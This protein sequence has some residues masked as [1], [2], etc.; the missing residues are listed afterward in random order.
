MNEP[1]NKTHWTKIIS[2][3]IL[4]IVSLSQHLYAQKNL[5]KFEHLT[6][7]Q[8]LLNYDVL[9]IVQDDKGFMWFATLDGL[10][11]YDGY[12]LKVY[13]QDP[14]VS[15]SLSDNPIRVVYEDRTGVLWIGTFSGGLNR[16]DRDTETFTHYQHNPADPNSLSNDGIRSIYQDRTGTL[17]IGTNGGGLNRFDSETEQ[18]THYQHDPDNPRSLGHDVI[19]VINEDRAG[20][21]WIGTE[22]GGLNRFDRKNETFI[23]Y[24]NNP[25]DPRSL[26]H[27]KVR[28]I[29]E[30]RTGGFWVGTFGGGLNRFDRDTETFTHYQHNPADP[31]S[32][33]D[34]DILS[35]Y[36]DRTGGLWIGTL[37]G[38]LN[39]FDRD[40][41]TFTHYQHNPADPH[42]L[43]HNNVYTIYED[44]TDVLW[45]GTFGG[46][47]RLDRGQKKFAHYQHNSADPNSLSNSDVLSIYEDKTGVL[48][49]GT[50]G[51]GLNHFDQETGTFTYYQH[52]SA[53]PGS[54]SNNSVCA[55]RGDGLDALWIG[56]WGGGLNRFD[57]ETETFTHYRHNP[58]NPHSLSDDVIMSIHKDRSG[59]L[60]IGTWTGG[61]DKLVLNEAKGFDREAA[62]FVHYQHNP[63]DP[64][65]LGSNS[66]M[67][68]YED[69]TGV[70]WV[71]TVNGGLNRFDHETETF[72]R[73]KND[74][75][76]PNSLSHNS[77]RSIYEDRAGVLWIGTWGGGLNRFDRESERFVRYTEKDGLPSNVVGGILEDRQ[78]N[79]WLSTSRGLS[80]FNPQMETFRNYNRTDGLQGNQ[81]NLNNGYYKSRSGEMFFGGTNGFN[82]FYPEQ[83]KDNP[84]IPPIAITNFQLANKPASIGGDSVLQQSIL[85]TG[86]L[87]LSYLDRVFSFEF[88]ALNYQSPEKNLYKYKLEGFDDG[89]NELDSTRRFATYTHLDQGE[90]VFR[91]IGSNNDGLWNEEGASIRIKITP[92]WWETIWFRV[93]ML[94]LAIG[95]IFG[96][97]R[98]RVRSIGRK[99]SEEALQEA[100]DELEK[101]V[102]E[103]TTE[104]IVAQDQI[105]R[106]ERLAATGQLAASVAHEINSPLQAITMLLGTMKRNNEENKELLDN[107]DLVKGSFFNIRNTVKNLMDLSRPGKER[108]QMINV[109]A[110][111]DNTHALMKS[112]IKKNKVRI[113]LN[114]SPTIPDMIA[115]PQQL[116]HV[117]LNV[118]NNAVEAMSDVSKSEA[119]WKERSKVGGEIS[120][121]TMFEKDHVVI[122]VSDTGPGIA[123]EDLEHIFDPFYT[124]KKTMGT[125]VGL[126]ICNGIIEDHDG[127]IE[128]RNAT[129]GG[130]VFTVTLP[131]KKE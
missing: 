35:I 53:K 45:I 11:R 46:V 61:L 57:R 19:F 52:D 121:K 15:D 76:N 43:S 111:I 107:I 82:A 98:W 97:S 114:L 117:F 120:I 102:K 51:G 66:V 124:K 49:I 77:V 47:D 130:A 74:P 26:S 92:P 103:R 27:N 84:H 3:T 75:D 29:F 122:Q 72:I 21:L 112:Y 68:I 42:S 87:T 50:N 86:D 65:S 116:G 38:G 119:K 104:L 115:S 127:I 31:Y 28:A 62:T 80:K 101:R 10:N 20:V 63:A 81:F 78:G 71:G 93:S 131:V 91:V 108:K 34:N 94:I 95:L 9:G 106:S 125:G 59:I 33:S 105:I 128:A 110:I 58:D 56:T 64:N 40:T 36:E 2:L 18:F 30:D 118:I 88:A 54:L 22:G 37:G 13:R 85:E 126:S 4:T 69:Q 83:I 12:N 99:Q 1:L 73:Y 90:Y 39:Q 60:W 7:E 123:E 23:R 8:G 6:I 129:E 44:R 96:V 16:F 25:D 41:E 55:I 89:W 67:S 14:E 100:H 70:L 79:L 113:D 32:L 17:W 109:N 24:Q 48:W 5:I